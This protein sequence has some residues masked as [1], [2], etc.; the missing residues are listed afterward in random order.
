M[1][2][3]TIKDRNLTETCENKLLKVR[4]QNV[5]MTL[6]AKVILQM[7]LNDKSDKSFMVGC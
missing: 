7:H 1:V 4:K 6:K 3:I 5:L 2:I